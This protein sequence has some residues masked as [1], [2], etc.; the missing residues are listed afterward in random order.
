VCVFT[1]DARFIVGT[2]IGYDQLQNLVLKDAIERVYMNNQVE[3]VPLGLYIIRGDNVAVISGDID[4][5]VLQKQEKEGLSSSA[6]VIKPVIQFT[7]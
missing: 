5:N 2:M 6:Q 1:C 7:L 4:E 3:L